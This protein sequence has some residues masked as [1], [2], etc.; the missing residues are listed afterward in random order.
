MDLNGS[1]AQLDDTSVVRIA[2]VGDIQPG[3]SSICVG[4]GFSSRYQERQPFTGLFDEVLPAIQ[5]RDLVFGN[6]EC[7]LSLSGL[8]PTNWHSAQMRGHPAFASALKRA[9]FNVLNVANNHAVQHG[10]QTFRE[11]LSLLEKA[12]IAACGLKG[13]GGWSSTPVTLTTVS[14]ARLG[15]LGYC[16]RPRQYGAAEPPYAEGDPDA[17]RRDVRRLSDQVDNVV[18]S[19][20]WGEE[21]VEAPSAEEVDWGHSFIDAGAVVVL[22]HHPHV[23]RPVESYRGGIIAYSL[24]NFVGDMVW[25]PPLRRGM[26]LQVDL[27]G[28]KATNVGLLPSTTDGN[29]R[30]VILSGARSTVAERGFA[31]LDS[32]R[33]ASEIRRT[34]GAQRRS[35]YRYAI[36]N[37]L[38]YPPQILGQLAWMTFKNKLGGMR[39]NPG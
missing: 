39:T 29:Y 1:E 11:T 31:G 3:D 7:T 13:T 10:E 16:L 15:I 23:V 5:G 4:F 37:L 19:L 25:Y 8:R 30:P 38:R 36:R 6:L 28:N 22:G 27:A 26:I 12:G 35:A 17:I 20:H 18:V 33:Y 32:Q 2:A 21:F 24:G 14:G 34:I 9:G